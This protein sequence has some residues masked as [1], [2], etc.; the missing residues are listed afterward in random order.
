[1]RSHSRFQHEFRRS[2]SILSIILCSTFTAVP[3]PVA[4]Q[5]PSQQQVKGEIFQMPAAFSPPKGRGAPRQS[6]GA[7]TRGNCF[8]SDRNRDNSQKPLTAL[9][10][11]NPADSNNNLGLTL[12]KNPT[13]LIYLPETLAK[14]AEFYLEEESSS[15]RNPQA[16]T[17]T[18]Y[19]AQISLPSQSGFISVELPRQQV[20]L[21]TNTSYRWYFTL[22]CSEAEDPTGSA[23]APFVSGVIQRV[24][25]PELTQQ[26]QTATA[27]QQ[28]FL[29]GKAGIWYDMIN[30]LAAL[31]QSRPRD[32]SLK[33]KWVTE[34]SS[35]LVQLSEIS[36]EPLISCC[37][38][39]NQGTGQR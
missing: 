25:Q 7:G 17:T 18:V 36:E 8:T 16:K 30:A 9:V 34:L 27:L 32:S 35:N 20:T 11:V 2:L 22:N 14:T 15:S 31:R 29:Y 21:K 24:E 38:A 19:T 26:L 39:R 3:N 4:A 10:P 12:S 23:G 13:V 6:L 5:S 33:T 28:V 1:M 37:S